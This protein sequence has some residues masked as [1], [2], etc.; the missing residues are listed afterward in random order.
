MNN[1]IKFVV[2][3]VVGISLALLRYASYFYYH[4]IYG[5]RHVSI[6]AYKKCCDR[7][8]IFNKSTSGCMLKGAEAEV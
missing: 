3:V 4:F 2:V 8:N 5:I 7:K 6:A 1:Y